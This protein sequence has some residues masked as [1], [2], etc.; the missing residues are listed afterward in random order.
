MET[1]SEEK[2]HLPI[3][4][5]GGWDCMAS[6]RNV[7]SLLESQTGHFWGHSYGRK[8][9]VECKPAPEVYQ[10]D[11]NVRTD[12]S[13]QC[14]IIMSKP[15]SYSMMRFL[16][17]MILC[18]CTLEIYRIQNII[19][20][21]KEKRGFFYLLNCSTEDKAVFMDISEHKQNIIYS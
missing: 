11:K 13:G 4:S 7:S 20:I 16:N 14:L 1:R 12:E 2:R 9:N 15:T 3:L 17:G 5:V 18:V 21:Q 6:S 19:R 10:E 8:S